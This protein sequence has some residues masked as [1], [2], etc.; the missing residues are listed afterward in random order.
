MLGFFLIHILLNKADFRIVLKDPTETIL[1]RE[2]SSDSQ[3]KI[4]LTHREIDLPYEFELRFKE[5]SDSIVITNAGCNNIMVITSGCRHLL[6]QTLSSKDI[7]YPGKSFEHF[8]NFHVLPYGLSC[9][10]EDWASAVLVRV[11]GG[12]IRPI[13]SISIDHFNANGLNPSITGLMVLHAMN[14]NTR[15]SRSIKKLNSEEPIF[16]NGKEISDQVPLLGRRSCCDFLTRL[17]S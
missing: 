7:A 5:V 3:S 1:T 13:L 15:L 4:V 10:A 8:R 12:Y 9:A 6:R 17:W 11:K 2:M 16:E 14:E